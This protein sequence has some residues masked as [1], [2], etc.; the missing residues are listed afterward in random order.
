MS[1]GDA[2][3]AIEPA[4]APKMAM[5]DRMVAG[6]DSVSRQVPANDAASEGA[7]ASTAPSLADV[8]FTVE[9]QVRQASHSRKAPPAS[10]SA[11]GTRSACSAPI[12]AVTPKA[13]TA[14]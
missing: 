12:S 14:P 4:S 5:K 7:A 6:L 13:P 10:A 3:A 1:S 11:N 8:G 2:G 9:R